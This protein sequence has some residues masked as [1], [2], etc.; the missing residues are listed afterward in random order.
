[1]IMKQKNKKTKKKIKRVKKKIKIIKEDIKKDSFEETGGWG[2][3]VGPV[4]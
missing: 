1:M 2:S 3:S 4:G